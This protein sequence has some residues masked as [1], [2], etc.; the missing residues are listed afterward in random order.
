MQDTALHPYYTRFIYYEL[1]IYYYI[2]YASFDYP[3]YN[4]FS[5]IFNYN[6]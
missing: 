3:Y 4:K 5:R 6:K 1:F 2:H